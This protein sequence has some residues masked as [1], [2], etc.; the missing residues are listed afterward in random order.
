MTAYKMFCPKCRKTWKGRQ[1]CCG[2]QTIYMGTRWRFPKPEDNKLKWRKNLNKL[3]WAR[4]MRND[5]DLKAL[6]DWSG[7]DLR[8]GKTPHEEAGERLLQ[9]IKNNKG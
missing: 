4:D 1:I 9:K 5:A 7:A 6:Y 3:E 8:F 2:R